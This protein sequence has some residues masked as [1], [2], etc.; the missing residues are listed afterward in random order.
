VATPPAT[1]MATEIDLFSEL[2]Q[3][4]SETIATS[5]PT[6]ASTGVDVYAKRLQG[7]GEQ[8]ATSP[9]KRCRGTDGIRK[10]T[11]SM[12]PHLKRLFRPLMG[13]DEAMV[14]TPAHVLVRKQGSTGEQWMGQRAVDVVRCPRLCPLLAHHSVAACSCRVTP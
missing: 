3:A 1:P 12:E 6:P 13:H 5:N 11:D 9:A 2:L 8:A 10:G 4:T 7:S 14:T